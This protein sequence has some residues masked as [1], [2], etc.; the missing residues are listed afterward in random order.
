MVVLGFGN[1]SN[2]LARY[3]HAEIQPPDRRAFAISVIVWAGT[4]GAV[5]GPSLIAPASRVARGWDL[6]ELAGPYL[7]SASFL[8][9]SF[10]LYALRLR[11]DPSSLAHAAIDDE[12][13]PG[14]AGVS[15]PEAVALP[16]DIPRDIPRPAILALTAMLAAQTVMV[17]I[18]T[19]TP[20]HLGHVGA[21]LGIVGLVMS[22]HTF[23]MFAL[24]PLFGRLA[25]RWGRLRAIVLGLAMLAV[26][27]LLALLLPVLA[28]GAPPPVLA[29]P[30]FVLGLGW[31][32]AFVSG[33]SLLAVGIPD[34]VRARLQGRVDAAV[35]GAGATASAAS[36]V[37][38]HAGSYAMLAGLGLAM[39]AVAA[40]L[41][42]GH[43]ARE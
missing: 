18:M 36:G 21:G 33:S 24:A 1:A 19:A 25:D 3:A 37:I 15:S 27:A 41:V 9:G 35:L 5:I 28:P 26:A 13:E 12:P 7:V 2:H 32:C 14:T 8:L 39:V 38:L 4:I 43:R 23:G 31:S 34:G 40:V 20:V 30:L 29:V 11:P 16:R 17:L 22:S 42:A 10:V 6:P